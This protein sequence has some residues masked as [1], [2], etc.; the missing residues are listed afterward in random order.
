L[1]SVKDGVNS[2]SKACKSAREEATRIQL[3]AWLNH[4][5]RS[6]IGL[7]DA[8]VDLDAAQT[9]AHVPFVKGS[10]DGHA[11]FVVAYTA[12][13]LAHVIYPVGISEAAWVHDLPR[14]ATETWTTSH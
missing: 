1:R 12:D 13:N 7:T 9:A 11:A 3:R 5:D 6:F 2:L 4:F 10:P 14:L 8:E